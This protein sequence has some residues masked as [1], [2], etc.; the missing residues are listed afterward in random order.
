M[1]EDELK[2]IIFVMTLIGVILIIRGSQHHSNSED[3]FA[4]IFF[5][6]FFL[7]LFCAVPCAV[8]IGASFFANENDIEAQVPLDGDAILGAGQTRPSS[9]SATSAM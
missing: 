2:C 4:E 5:G 3:N 8:S 9:P 1:C 7:A 6:T